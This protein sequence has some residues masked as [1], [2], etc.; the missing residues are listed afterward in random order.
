[1]ENEDALGAIEIARQELSEDDFAEEYEC[2]RGGGTASFSADLL[3][4]QMHGEALVDI[5]DLSDYGDLVLGADIGTAEH[6]TVVSALER[7]ADGVWRQSALTELRR[8]GLPRQTEV[9]I[10]LLN[11]LPRAVLAIDATGIGTHIGQILHE[12]FRRRVIPMKIGSHPDNLPSQDRAE[13]VTEFKRAMEAAEVE[14]STD[15]E[16][17]LQ[18][19]RTKLLSGGKVEQR[20][21]KK[22]THYD[23]AWATMYAWYAT[24]VGRRRSVYERRGLRV[25][26]IGR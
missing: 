11:R 16:Q 25:L 13:Y 7:H 24:R 14:I 17:A 4:R 12:R 10:E 18:F 26:N 5:S 6:P 8:M 22:K 15:R 20:G 21:S 9:F 19:R 2:V 3:R 23:R 1:V